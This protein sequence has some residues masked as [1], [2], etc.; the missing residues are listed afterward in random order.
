MIAPLAMTLLPMWR[1]KPNCVFFVFFVVNTFL[2][3]IWNY[4]P[5]TMQK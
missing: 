1:Q 2:D 4:A 3:V 5:G